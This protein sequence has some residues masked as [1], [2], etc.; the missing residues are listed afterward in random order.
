MFV[1][2][3][4]L[5]NQPL[6]NGDVRLFVRLGS[7]FTNNYYE[8]EI[9]L[10]L[11]AP[12]NYDNNSDGDRGK[13][14]PERN[15]VEIVFA[16]LTSAKLKRNEINW[17]LTLPYPRSIENGRIIRVV[18]N[19]NIAALTNIMVGIYNPVTADGT[20]KC[21]EVWINEL[22]LTDFDQ[23]GGWAANSRVTAK[24]ADFGQVSVSGAVTTPFYG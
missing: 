19:P 16:D 7:D 3:E 23:Q 5:N 12:G 9:P 21:A 6:D 10:D 15:N 24:L 22:R 14:W 20:N 13:V 4:K 8:Y 1:H 17:P 18:G 11:T 2:G